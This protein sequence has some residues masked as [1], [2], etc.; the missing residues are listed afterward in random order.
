MTLLP[1][2]ARQV[3]TWYFMEKMPFAAIAQRL[4][5]TANTAQK[6]CERALGRL[7]K[8]LGVQTSPRRKPKPR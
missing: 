5:C 1:E 3:L 8:A 2:K 4:D 6:V 7:R